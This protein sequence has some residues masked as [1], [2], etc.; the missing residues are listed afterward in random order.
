MNVRDADAVKAVVDE[1]LNEFGRI[2]IVSANA[3]IVTVDSAVETTKEQW[4]DNIDVNLSGV[5]FA[6]QPVLPSMIER[7]E[8]GS[9]IIT[10]SLYGVT[11]PP[12]NLAAYTAAKHGVV[13]LMRDSPTSSPVTAFG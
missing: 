11:G 9:I 2:D 8:G 6:I 7:G 4:N 13:D 3:G 1:G 10:S 12:G 5:W